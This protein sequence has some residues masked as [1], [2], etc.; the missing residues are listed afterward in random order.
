MGVSKDV[1][2]TW[3]NEIHAWE[4]QT[5]RPGIV[6]MPCFHESVLWLEMEEQD[7]FAIEKTQVAMACKNLQIG[8]NKLITH[9]TENSAGISN[10]ADVVRDVVGGG[11]SFQF[12]S[13]DSEKTAQYTFTFN[14]EENCSLRSDQAAFT[15]SAA[16]QGEVVFMSK[17]IDTVLR[18]KMLAEYREPQPVKLST[19]LPE[20]AT[21][22]EE[23][24]IEPEPAPEPEPEPVQEPVIEP[25]VEV[26][27]EEAPP[28]VETEPE[29]DVVLIKPEEEPA[30]EELNSELDVNSLKKE[31]PEVE[32]PEQEQVLQVILK[33]GDTIELETDVDEEEY[34][35]FNTFK[36]TQFFVTE[37]EKSSGLLTTDED[38]GVDESWF[39]QDSGAGVAN[40]ILLTICFIILLFI[41][42][43]L[44]ICI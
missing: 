42:L 13:L 23:V 24:A 30:S 9:L 35:T 8:Y 43:G 2:I 14:V 10:K 18:P 32:E 11:A 22:V 3:S 41:C 20:P 38:T 44:Y 7:T 25:V 12:G 40:W 28:I 1:M 19:S 39:E 36:S 17:D 31:V 4:T 6:T 29:D 34:S 15:N 27:E 5:F 37:F 16:V 26:I 33:T 21:K